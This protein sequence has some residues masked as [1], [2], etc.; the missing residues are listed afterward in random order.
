[1]IRGVSPGSGGIDRPLIG[2]STFGVFLGL[3]VGKD[4]HHAVDPDPNGKATA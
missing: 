2:S 3:D 1:M 4:N